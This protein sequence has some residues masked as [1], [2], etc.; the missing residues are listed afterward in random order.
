MKMLKMIR[1]NRKKL[2]NKGF[3]LIELL[4]VI[5]ILAIVMGISATSVLN[6]INNSRKSSLYSTAQNAANTLNTWISEDMIETNNTKKKLG[7]AFLTSSQT[8]NWICFDTTTT[9]TNGGTA[10]KLINALGFSDQDIVIGTKY[11]APST[12]ALPGCSA[13]RYNKG[14]GGYEILL[15]AKQNG[16][17]WVSNNGTNGVSN[18]AY[19]RANAAGTAI[20]D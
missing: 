18:Y 13:Y 14:T 11:S 2:D 20:N 10:A 17:F 1:K 15:V 8:G 12:S 4:A 5:V 6:S 16:K 9:I 3:T 19:S 7:D